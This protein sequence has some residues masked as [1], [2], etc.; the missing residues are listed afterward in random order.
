M[1]GFAL[2]RS[3]GSGSRRFFACLAAAVLLVACEE[4]PPDNGGVAPPARAGE[5]VPLGEGFDF[6]VLSLSWSP[7]YCE[8]E[9][10][11]A[12]AQQCGSG[13]PHGFVV[14]GLWPQWEKGYPQDCATSEPDVG[15]KQLR[16]LYDLT[17]SAGLIRHQWRKHG[18]CAGLAQAE[19]FEVVRAA[20]DRVQ[21]PGPAQE[22]GA[23]GEIDPTRLEQS[24]MD[25]NP[26]LVEDGIAITCD[27]GYLREARICMTRMLRFRACPEVN[28]R[29]CR[30]RSVRMPPP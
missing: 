12:N 27:D 11:G 20:R 5:P 21:L 26:G 8:S 10:A 3:G 9:G 25:A 15:A 4:A 7:S 14:H 13:R 30:A 19:Y 17:P 18:T 29:A 24:F 23:P 22:S 2:I 28:A 16:E 6:Y 1:P